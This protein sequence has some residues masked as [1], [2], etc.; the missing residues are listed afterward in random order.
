VH[1]SVAWLPPTDSDDE[2][3]PLVCD[4]D[5]DD[6]DPEEPSKEE[7]SEMAESLKGEGSIWR[8][9]ACRA[10]KDLDMVI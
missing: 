6:A 5:E 7:T 3:P 4:V 1:I 10:D 8:L 2:G 9:S